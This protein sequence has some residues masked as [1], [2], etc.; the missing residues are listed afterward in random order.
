MSWMRPLGV[1]YIMTSDCKNVHFWGEDKQPNDHFICEKALDDYAFVIWNYRLCDF[2][3]LL[4]IMQSNHVKMLTN[5]SHV[6][7]K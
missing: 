4:A 5:I 3:F 6:K 7:A 2:D 1:S